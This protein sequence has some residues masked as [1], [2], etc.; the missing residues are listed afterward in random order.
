MGRVSSHT[1][2]INGTTDDCLRLA[3]SVFVEEIYSA[4]DR[5]SSAAPG[6][7]WNRGT[8]EVTRA[9][10]NVERVLRFVS[11]FIESITTLN[12]IKAQYPKSAKRCVEHTPFA[13][14]LQVL[15]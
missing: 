10:S 8:V 11:L 2:N 4:C 6:T 7:L 15:C 1:K 9:D 13:F 3:M 5:V 14:C 12:S